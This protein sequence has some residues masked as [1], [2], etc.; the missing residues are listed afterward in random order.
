MLAEV[1]EKLKETGGA[2][3]AP[4]E[5][6]EKLKETGGAQAAPSETLSPT[7]SGLVTCDL[8]T[9]TSKQRALMSCLVCLVSYCETHLQTHYQV[10]GLKKHKLV[11]ATCGLQE[12]IC[13]SHD[14]LLEVFCRTDQQCICVLCMDD[15][16][17]GHDTVSA[18]VESVE[19]QVIP[20]YMIPFE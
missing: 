9:G 15:E 13:S 6:V 16:H 7:A 18:K 20:E 3:A 4:S 2:Q 19:K 1:V 5:V 12:M 8:C 11:K 10:P 17:K 14:K